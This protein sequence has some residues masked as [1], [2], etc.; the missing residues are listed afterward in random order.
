MSGD[1]LWWEEVD[2]AMAADETAAD[3]FAPSPT[4]TVLAQSFASGGCHCG[5]LPHLC[6]CEYYRQLRQGTLERQRQAEHRASGGIL[7]LDD[8]QL[9]ASPSEGIS[10]E[11]QESVKRRRITGKRSMHSP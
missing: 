9:D 4:I 7:H 11:H 2:V 1:Q 10:E 8:T 3:F 5:K 6:T